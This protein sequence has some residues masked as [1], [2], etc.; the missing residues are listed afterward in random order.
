MPAQK[1]KLFYTE[2]VFYIRVFF[3]IKFFFTD[4]SHTFFLI[5]YHFHP[6]TNIQTIICNFTSNMTTTAKFLIAVHVITILLLNDIYPPS[7]I[8]IWLNVK[9]QI[10]L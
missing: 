3:Y 2:Y 9:L 4:K 6:L 5:L 10:R 7:G 8:S 1:F